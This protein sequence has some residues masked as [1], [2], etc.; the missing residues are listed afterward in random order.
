LVADDRLVDDLDTGFVQPR[1]DE[2]GIGVLAKRSQQ[3]GTD[4]NNLGIHDE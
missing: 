3:F 2:Q 1:G 4:G